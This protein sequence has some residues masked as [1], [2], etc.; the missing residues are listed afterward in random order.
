MS[1]GSSLL[2]EASNNSLTQV[3]DFPAKVFN[4]LFNSVIQAVPKA[5][6]ALLLIL[7]GWVLAVIAASILRKALIRAGI[8]DWLE[9][10]NLKKALFNIS[11]SEVGAIAI[12]WYIIIIF[13]RE[14]SFRI[15]LEALTTLLDGIIAAI[16]NLIVGVGIIIGALAVA[17][18]LRDKISK[19]KFIFSEIVGSV[20]YGVIIYFA[21]ILALPKLG[22]YNIS[23][24]EDTFK[25]FVI[26]VSVGVSVAIGIG[27]GFAIKEGPAKNFFKKWNK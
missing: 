9:K 21:I 19:E 26:G 11:V 20:I 15:G 13:L 14:V 7:I 25:F 23:V 1:T 4:D 6:T 17:S 5:L 27:F 3:I 12:K 24:L 18:V 2:M 10:R 22:F 8:D 16:P